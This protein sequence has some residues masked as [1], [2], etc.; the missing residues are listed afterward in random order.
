MIKWQ[1]LESFQTVITSKIGCA[2]HIWQDLVY[3]I[4]RLRGEGMRSGRFLD[5]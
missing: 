4:G 1:L 2:T 3:E 5:R